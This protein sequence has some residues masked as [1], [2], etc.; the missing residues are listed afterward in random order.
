MDSATADATSDHWKRRLTI[1]FYKTS[2]AARY[3][4]SNRATV[5]RW[6]RLGVMPGKEPRAEMSYLQLIEFAVAAAMRRAS[7]PLREIKEAH[8]YFARVFSTEFPFATHRFKADGKR[9]VLDYKE[10]EPASELDRLVYSDG[11]LG[12]KELVDPLLREFDYHD[13][14][15][16][17]RWHVAGLSSKVVIDP[18]VSFGAPNVGGA[19]TWVLRDRYHAGESVDDIADDFDLSKDSVLDALRFES[20]E[21][22]LERR[23]LWLN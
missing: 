2:E 17:I 10:V 4:R 23:S 11:Q 3:A 8:D 20:V 16:A 14:G 21:P 22:D 13:E 9:V 7:I 1:P 6:H 19:A 18:Q 12:W 5:S 15:L